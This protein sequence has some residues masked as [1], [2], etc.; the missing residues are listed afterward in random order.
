MPEHPADGQAGTPAGRRGA[1]SGSTARC[2]GAASGRCRGAATRVSSYPC[3]SLRGHDGRD[4]DPTPASAPPAALATP[5]PGRRCRRRGRPTSRPARCCTGSAP[6]TGCPSSRPPTRSAARWCTRCW[7]G[8]STC[9][10]A[11]APPAAAGGLVAPQWERL[12]RASG[13]EL[14]ELFDAGRRGGRPPE[15]LG[16]AS[17]AARRLLRGRG[18]APARAGRAGEPGLHAGRRRA[19]DPRLH[20]PARRLPRRRP[21]GGRLQDRRRAAGGVRGAGRCSS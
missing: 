3:P 6:S 20:R 8:C 16:S 14:A 4:G 17:G 10:P 5:G 12:R 15:F 21:A 18:P 11:S 2:Y 1:G 7:S 9:R 13:R 19:A